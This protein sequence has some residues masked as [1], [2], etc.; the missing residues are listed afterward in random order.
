M[1]EITAYISKAT[2]S[3]ASAEA[4]YTVGRNNSC[5]N[6]IYYACFQA[7]IAALLFDNIRPANPRG[8]WSH[9]FVQSQFNGILIKRRKR[10][11]AHLRRVLRDTIEVRQKADYTV[12]P[13]SSSVASR[14]LRQGRAF[15]QTI[16]EK[17]P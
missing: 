12:S 16:Q 8:E 17:L 3:L 4:D 13:V 2:E 10:Y 6:R 1:E 14:V 5:A 9:E 15:V 11:P 7:A